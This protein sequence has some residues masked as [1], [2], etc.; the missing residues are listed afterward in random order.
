MTN[1]QNNCRK[2]RLN[3]GMKQSICCTDCQKWY[4]FKCSKISLNEFKCHTQD[5]EKEWICQYCLT[6]KCSHCK[7]IVSSKQNGICCDLCNK[8]LHLKC[9]SL[10]KSTFS[11]LHPSDIWWC[12]QCIQ[13]CFPFSNI[14]NIQLYKLFNDSTYKAKKNSKICARKACRVCDKRNMNLSKGICCMQ[15]NYLTHRKC[16]GLSSN[17]I[18]LNGIT[19]QFL[20][21][22][23][24]DETFPFFN[25]NI[26][27]ILDATFNSN[28]ACKCIKG[29]EMNSM[30]DRQQSIL[31]M[32]NLNFNKFSNQ[33]QHDPDVGIVN[34]T[35]FSYYTTHDLHKLS[36]NLKDRNHFSIFHSNICSLQ[37]NFEKLELLL[38]DIELEFDIVALTET[39]NP[40]DSKLLFTPGI[41]EGYH[42]YTGIEGNSQ[43]GGCGLY[44][45]KKLSYIPREDLDISFKN[46]ESEFEVK[47]VEIK[48][49]NNKNILISV[50][51]RHPRNSDTKYINY[52]KN[53]F[54][55][56]RKENKLTFFVGDFNYNLIKHE[57]KKEIGEFFNLMT[58]NLM[59][60]HILGPSR[61][62]FGS[63]PSLPDNIFVNN[64]DNN[65]TNGNLYQ[66]IS[67][68]MPNFLIMENINCKNKNKT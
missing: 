42:S 17:Y 31:N 35:N 67:D 14:N 26:D 52:L 8:W 33:A 61:V 24:L 49:E 60:P 4:H 7:K 2:C 3:L 19:S 51:Y 58:S 45:N 56:I 30:K 59:Q 28:Y 38:N 64:L 68:H 23:C 46:N 27:E 20:C 12:K 39:W 18:D 36:N 63:K 34:N 15:C 32:N 40:V 5:Q 6:D 62:T 66:S 48:N 55:K 57:T 53:T 11:K 22:K 9:S 43:K 41:L 50:H 29:L 1:L 21:F 16:T 47:W 37:G 54:K 25:C 65:F 10:D 13:E 44:I